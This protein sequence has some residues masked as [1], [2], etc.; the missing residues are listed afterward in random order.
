MLR[1]RQTI[2][3]KYTK[4]FDKHATIDRIYNF[5]ASF[6][7]RTLRNYLLQQRAFW[8]LTK[9]KTLQIAQLSKPSCFVLHSLLV[10]GASTK[11][12]TNL[13]KKQSCGSVADILA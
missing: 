8:Q 4:F 12:A 13:S 10:A 5:I 6:D 1:A 11:Q 2:A 7:D 3:Q 9:Q